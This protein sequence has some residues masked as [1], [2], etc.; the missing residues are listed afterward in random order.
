MANTELPQLW[1]N[2]QAITTY[3]TNFHIIEND[4]VNSSRPCGMVWLRAAVW[5][6]GVLLYEST[7]A[8]LRVVLYSPQ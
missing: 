5:R 4:L 2:G 6:T 1:R 8:R 7:R 3:V